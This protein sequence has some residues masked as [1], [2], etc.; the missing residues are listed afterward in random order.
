M[1]HR[2]GGMVITTSNP[3]LRVEQQDWSELTV[4]AWPASWKKE[5]TV[6]RV[7]SRETRQPNFVTME[8]LGN[9]RMHVDISPDV[10]GQPRAW[11][12]RFHLRPNQRL[13]LSADNMELEAT[14]QHIAPLPHFRAK[15]VVPFKGKGAAPAPGAGPVAEVYLPASAKARSLR[16]DFH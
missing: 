1:W 8:T 13:Q 6:R 16:A 7:Y 3:G 10:D 5:R 2:V 9:G 14:V 15:E 4:E 12:L 11:V